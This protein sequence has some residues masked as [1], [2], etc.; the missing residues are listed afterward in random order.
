MHLE[1]LRDNYIKNGYNPI[2]ASAKICQ[3]IILSKISKSTLNKIV[4]IKGG[5]VMH[6]LSNDKR[7]ATKDIDLDFIRYSLDNDS[8]Q[9][10][11]R[12]N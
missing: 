7:R 8:I 2:N 4:T 1:K 6:S 11:I 9:N 12:N 3:D 5:V 10:F